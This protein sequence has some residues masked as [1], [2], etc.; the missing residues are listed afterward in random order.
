MVVVPGLRG[1]LALAVVAV[2]T[3]VAVVG[4]RVGDLGD[5]VVRERGVVLLDGLVWIDVGLGRWG[6][7]LLLRRCLVYMVGASV[8]LEA[9]VLVKG[10]SAT[11]VFLASVAVDR[12]GG[13]LLALGRLVRR[14]GG[15]RRG[16]PL[17]VVDETLL[18][19]EALVAVSARERYRSMA[20]LDLV[21]LKSVGVVKVPV[22]HHADVS[23]R[24]AAVRV[25]GEVIAELAVGVERLLADTAVIYRRAHGRGYLDCLLLR[26]H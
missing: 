7:R 24:V 22:A 16:A 11:E 8:T 23:S 5:V 1:E 17:L 4:R 12:H 15:C 25:A 18:C 20:A 2:D 19:E 13:S 26:H 6:S 3:A 9:P 21:K 14:L 10:L